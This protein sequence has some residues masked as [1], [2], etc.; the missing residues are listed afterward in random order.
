MKKKGLCSTCAYD[1]DC[2]FSRIFPVLRC[3]EFD[4]YGKSSQKIKNDK[5]S[6]QK[7]QKIEKVLAH[8]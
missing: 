1:K 3:E 7:K 4:G 6:K 5:K 2:D 8:N